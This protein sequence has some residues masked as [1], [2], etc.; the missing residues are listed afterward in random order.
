MSD[1]LQSAA[2]SIRRTS[3]YAN[4]F[5]KF[6]VWVDNSRV[7]TIEDGDRVRFSLTP[8]QHSVFLKIDC[9]KSESITLTLTPG[10]EIPLVCGS[11]MVGWHILLWIFYLIS[12]NY[13]YLRQ[14]SA[15]S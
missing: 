6:S 8:G 13:I 14:E 5:S 7:G 3:Q 2:V 15:L 1:E 10:D 9:C 4:R 12:G 11:D